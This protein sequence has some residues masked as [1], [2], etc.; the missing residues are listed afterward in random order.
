MILRPAAPLFLL[1]LLAA[2]GGASQPPVA[3][4]PAAQARPAGPVLGYQNPPATGFRLEV[5]PASNHT[6]RL[7]LHLKGP[8]GLT[9]RGVACFLQVDPARLAWCPPAAGAGLVRNGGT[10]GLAS[11]QSALIGAKAAQG[12]L[13]LGV[14]QREAQPIKLGSAPLASIA[15]EALPEAAQGPVEWNLPGDRQ[16]VYLDGER[17]LQPL[18]LAL[19]TL[20]VE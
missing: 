20:T 2:C 17:Q 11:A 9:A 14:F 1:G 16:P 4:A 18:T 19:G 13:Q 5:D 3:P 12:L 7:V 6:R 8:G 10:W 15:L